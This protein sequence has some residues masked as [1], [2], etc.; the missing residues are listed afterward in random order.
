MLLIS[1][2]GQPFCYALFC[3][4]LVVLRGA[5]ANGKSLSDGGIRA[6]LTNRP[7]RPGKPTA[8]VGA[9]WDNRLAGEVIAL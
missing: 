4:V 5:A 7:V 9:E 6:K 8:S 3:A 2:I 1:V